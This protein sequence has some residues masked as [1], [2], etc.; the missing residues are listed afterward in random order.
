M[1]ITLVNYDAG[2]RSTAG[3]F[4]GWNADIGDAA[5]DF[6][7]TA[8]NLLVFGFG[9]RDSGD[10]I[11]PVFSSITSGWNFIGMTAPMQYHIAGLAWK[12]SNGTETA[13]T[14]FFTETFGSNWYWVAEFNSSTV[15]AWSVAASVFNG[16]G[17]TSTSSIASGPTG[18]LP[19][20][21]GVVVG[22]G[23]SRTASEGLTLSGV[24]GLQSK[25]QMQALN[26]SFWL[27]AGS[28][29]FA[30]SWGWLSST[31]SL[32]L[33]VSESTGSSRMGAGLVVF[34]DGSS[35]NPTVTGTAA[36]SISVIGSAYG[37]LAT[38]IFHGDVPVD[39][40][41]VGD[42]LVDRIYYGNV[43]VL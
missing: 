12:V 36:G 31:A 20:D 16:S 37:A 33:S 32:N 4:P 9:G 21:V 2:N 25:S 10:T 3:Y 13:V 39:A 28:A 30:A 22:V 41:Y 17:S 1:T 40:V 43:R 26:G 19:S 7:P 14:A 27:D 23:T 11:S 8:G 35:S 29:N 34:R 42:D 24:S 6:T 15:T 38:T 5:F 18:V